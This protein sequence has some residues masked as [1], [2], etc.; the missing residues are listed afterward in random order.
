MRPG[1]SLDAS[2]A[3]YH[4]QVSSERFQALYPRVRLEAL[5]DGIY[6]VAMTLLVLDV[7]LP[8]DF[9][10]GSAAQLLQGL[11]DLWPKVFPYL[12]SF[13]VLGLRWLA[14]V[15]TRSRAE[16]LGGAYIRWWLLHLLLITCVPFTTIVVGRY[17]SLAPAVWLYAGNIGLLAAA[18]WWQL[19]LLPDV[20]DDRH[21][22]GRQVPSLLLLGSAVVCIVWSLFDS[23]HALWAFVLNLAGPALRRRSRSFDARVA[24]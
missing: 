12:L 5:T 7:R 18:S 13:G 22:R 11:T 2:R 16:L 3:T 9:R 4:G 6:A 14:A 17:A 1:P 20:D 10:P 23:P 21:L 15:Q 8:E 19:N 24:P